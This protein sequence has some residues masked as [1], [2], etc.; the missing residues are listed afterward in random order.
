MLA[1]PL[2]AH[3]RDIDQE[4]KDIADAVLARDCDRATGLMTSH[5]EITTNL[6]LQANMV[7]EK[8]F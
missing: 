2:G 7:G 8:V 1:A 5:F 3:T 4:H 6:I